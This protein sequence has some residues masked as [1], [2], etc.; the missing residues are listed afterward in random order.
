MTIRCHS[1][2]ATT[3]KASGW[4][5]EDGGPRACHLR[6]CMRSIGVPSA[7]L[8]RNRQANTPAAAALK[9]P[10]GST[11]VEV[12]EF[13]AQRYVDPAVLAGWQLEND[14][15]EEDETIELMVQASC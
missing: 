12:K 3:T 4:Y 11:L 15:G 6:E 5:G 1:C 14:I 2:G 8:K 7:Q 9:P 13:L 10:G